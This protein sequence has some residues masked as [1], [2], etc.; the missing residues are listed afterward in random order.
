MR[1]SA[2]PPNIPWVRVAALQPVLEFLESI[3]VPADRYLIRNGL[4]HLELTRSQDLLPRHAVG[5]FLTDVSRSEGVD[6][7]SWRAVQWLKN[8]STIYAPPPGAPTL[9]QALRRLVVRFNS[10]TSLEFGMVEH[11]HSVLFYRRQRFN[12]HEYDFEMAWFALAAAVETI[13]SYAGVAWTPARM[14]TPPL[15]AGDHSIP[16]LFSDVPTVSDE[17]CHWVEVPR[18]HLGLEPLQPASVVGSGARDRLSRKNQLNPAHL[19]AV[20]SGILK[21]YVPSGAPT[22]ELIADQVGLSPRTLKRRLQSYGK[23]YSGLLGETRFGLAR[24]MLDAG[25]YSITEIAFDLGYGSASN[26]ARAFRRMAGVTPTQY[27]L[28]RLIRH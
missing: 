14:A 12:L 28:D 24:E 2:S 18:C 27:R 17:L 22:V 15:A 13:R 4:P 21:T 11:P 8:S 1:S 26:F 9:Y 23:T 25:D 19:P 7:M 16:R 3:K 10:S 20:L 5:R 6:K